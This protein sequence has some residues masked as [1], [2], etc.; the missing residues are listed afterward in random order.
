MKIHVFAGA[1]VLLALV[2]AGTL[3]PGC[4]SKENNTDAIDGGVVK[5][6]SGDDA[7][8]VIES[9]EITSFDV[10]F[11][12]TTLSLEKAAYL[13]NKRFSFSAALE[14]DKVRGSYRADESS[15]GSTEYEF[16]THKEF[17]SELQ[18]IVSEYDFAKLNGKM[19]S[20]SGLPENFGATINIEYASGESIYS[21][22][23]QHNFL[24][25]DAMKALE[26]L[27]AS[28]AAPV[29]ER[30]AVDVSYEKSTRKENGGFI[31][32]SYPK[33]SYLSGLPGGDSALSGRYAAFIEKLSG[34][35][36]SNEAEAGSASFEPKGSGCDLY[37]RTES[38]PC[39]SDTKLFSFYERVEYLGS[40][41]WELPTRF[42]RPY[43]IDV[44]TG[45]ELGFYEAFTDPAG[46]LP[47]LLSE[48]LRREM[49]EEDFYPD[50]EDRIERAI[51]ENT[52]ELG[53]CIAP[54]KI[55]FFFEEY[56][57]TEEHSDYELS[58]SL[59]E[60]PGLLLT[61]LEG[62]APEGE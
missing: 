8:K 10:Y 37:F 38:F 43:N 9:S 26:L 31:E 6:I 15:G 5:D 55:H 62:S 59:S 19:H 25:A 40:D 4:G 60:Y 41:Y 36:E 48:A 14:G 44:D 50:I 49:P 56:L 22:D 11:S 16:E 28:A 17:M 20:V 45:R 23:N 18:D 39:R 35:S 24:S 54:G 51:A 27:F 1:A 42:V 30:I 61:F 12:T 53:F 47:Y 21:S 29:P 3:L 7:P 52:G 46:K 2:A 34:I 58:L 13:E 32:L 33:Y 57:L